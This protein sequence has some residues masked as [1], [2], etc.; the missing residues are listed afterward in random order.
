MFNRSDVVW[1]NISSFNASL[2]QHLV[3]HN[4]EDVFQNITSLLWLDT[5]AL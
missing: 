2:N 5:D 1:N 4:G 3:T